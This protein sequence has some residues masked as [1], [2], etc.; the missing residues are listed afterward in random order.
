MTVLITATR[1]IFT[2]E[3]TI[4][5]WTVT[6]RGETRPLVP[7]VIEDVDRGLAARMGEKI[8][9]ELK[10]KGATA[11]PIGEYPI[12]VTFSPRFGRPMPQILGVPG[13]AGIRIHGGVRGRATEQHTEGCPIPGMR[14]IGPDEIEGTGEATQLVYAVIDEAKSRGEDVRIRIVRDPAT[15][16]P[17]KAANPDI[18]KEDA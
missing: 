18:V 17:F 11:I 6:H 7:A 16:L 13:Y 9:L 3:S 2:R 10:V 12:V 5:S 1:S 8:I 4:S 14:V 15:W